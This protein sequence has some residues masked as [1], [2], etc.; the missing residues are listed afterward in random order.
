MD[1]PRW[2]NSDDYA[3]HKGQLR[4]T[5][6]ENGALSD[7][8]LWHARFFDAPETFDSSAQSANK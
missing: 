4:K 3:T 2:R 6:A 5:F 7:A 8:A 1:R